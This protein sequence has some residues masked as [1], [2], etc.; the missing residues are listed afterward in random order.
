[1][2][3][4]KLHS[5]KKIKFLIAG[6]ACA[7]LVAALS[8]YSIDRAD[9]QDAQQSTYVSPAEIQLLQSTLL[10]KGIY[11]GTPLSPADINLRPPRPQNYLEEVSKYFNFYVLPISW[12][13][14]EQKGRG[15]FDFSYTDKVADFAIAHHAKLKGHAL[16]FGTSLPAWLTNGNFSP[17]ELKAI[18]KNHVQTVV[19]HYKNKYPGQVIEWNVVN[20]PTCNGG[21]TTDPETCYPEGVKKN[22]WSVIHKPGSN[23]PTDYIQL[24]FQW[25]HEADPSAKLFINDDGIEAKAHPKIERFYSLIKSLVDKH[26]PID[27]VGF[28]CH[29][30]LD[31]RSRFSASSLAATMDRFADLGLESQISELDVLVNKGS[32]RG[33][34]AL[35]SEPLKMDVVQTSDFQAQAEFYRMFLDAALQAKKCTGFITWGPW[36]TGSYTFLHWKA[37][38]YPHLLDSNL[39]PKL[40]FKYLVNEA[41]AYN[42]KANR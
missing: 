14:S 20:E 12:L 13:V 3:V 17:D 32:F 10:K 7:G 1:M 24:A 2:I 26:V 22:I 39:K 38:F 42:A 41:K 6:I 4:L 19:N 25:A 16:V 33:A 8:L 18:L 28:E 27:G 21:A 37:P 11:F 9:A 31:T 35:A 5:M 15:V 23:D 36:D 34:Q 40:A 30:R 29:V